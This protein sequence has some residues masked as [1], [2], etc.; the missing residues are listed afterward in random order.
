MELN[1]AITCINFLFSILIC[2]H[3]YLSGWLLCW[4]AMVWYAHANKVKM[5]HNTKV[6]MWLCH[7][8]KAVAQTDGGT[9]F[10]PEPNPPSLLPPCSAINTPK[11][12]FCTLWHHHSWNSAAEWPLCIHHHWDLWTHFFFIVRLS[13]FVTHEISCY[14]LNANQSISSHLSLSENLT[15]AHHCS[16][17]A[18]RKVRDQHRYKGSSSGDHRYL[19]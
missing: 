12:I 2:P 11:I 9:A 6:N 3:V 1:S 14:T 4:W 10:S 13:L 5:C 17:A 16:T 15:D 8:G 19:Q 7:L 18:R